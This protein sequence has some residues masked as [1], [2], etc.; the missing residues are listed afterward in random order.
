MSVLWNPNARIKTVE[1][2]GAKDRYGNASNEVVFSMIE[3]CRLE[4]STKFS[5]TADGSLLIKDAQV[6]VEARWV[7]RVGDVLTIDSQEEDR[8]NVHD[9]QE[10]LDVLGNVQFRIYGLTR[11]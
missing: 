4:R 11:R 10:K 1:R 7:F 2:A 6:W 5:R 8:Y 9:V 3:G